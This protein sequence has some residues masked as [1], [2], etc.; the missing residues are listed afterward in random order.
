VLTPSEW[1]V[2]DLVRHG[3]SNREIA[4]LRGTSSDATKYH[5]AN[6]TAKLELEGRAQ[7][8]G[9]E[10]VPADSPM[11]ARRNHTMDE[12]LRLGALAQVSQPVSDIER[13]VAWYGGRL[14]LPHLF[15]FGNLAFF[16][17]GGTRLFLSGEPG[18]PR[19]PSA[20]ILYFRV[21]DI[22][23]AH[24]ELG[25]RGVTFE[26]APHRV[27][28]HPDGTEEWMAVFRDPDGNLLALMSQ[29]APGTEPAT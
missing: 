14:G 18:S 26:G 12:P 10:G 19:P 1:T 29:V 7:L 25:E 5:V 17:C 20:T 4:R 3:L 9:W 8:R 28:R 16:D 27:H 24:H 22:A 6:V 13:S 23:A 21:A 11:R 15:T 2:T